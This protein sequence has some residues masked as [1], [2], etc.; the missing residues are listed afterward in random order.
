MIQRIDA[1]PALPTVINRVLQVSANPGATHTDLKKIIETDSSLVVE[2]LKL[3]NSPFFGQRRRVTTLEHGISLLGMTEIR[4]LVLAKT[5]FQTFRS[6]DDFNTIILWKHSFYCGLA[7]RIMAEPF[8]MDANENFVAGLIHDIGKLIAYMELDEKNLKQLELNRFVFGDSTRKEV[9]LLGIS[10]DQ[11]GAKLLEKWMFPEKLVIAVGFHHRPH[12]AP[13]ET[14]LFPL[15]VHL[16]NLLGHI[17]EPGETEEN[18]ILLHKMFLEPSIVD[19]AKNQKLQLNSTILEVFIG[20]LT[21]AI[22]K[23]SEIITLLS[24]NSERNI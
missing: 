10:H 6:I 5:M 7:A 20:K 9:K 12:H 22:E 8:H 23:E 14:R 21:A 17:C 11:L 16:A 4:N 18:K 15:M 19:L 24:G 2:V 13:Q 3:A 1:F